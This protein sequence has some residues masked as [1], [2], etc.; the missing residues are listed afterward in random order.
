MRSALC[1]APV[2]AADV[3]NQVLALSEAG[4]L[5]SVVG[6]SSYHQDATFARV[7]RKIAPKLHAKTESRRWKLEVQPGDCRTV[8][9]PEFSYR[10][11]TALGFRQT[12]PLATDEWFA[13]IDRAASRFVQQGDQLVLAREDALMLGASALLCGGSVARA[14]SSSGCFLN[15]T[16]SVQTYLLFEAGLQFT[17]VPTDVN[18]QCG[19]AFNASTASKG[20]VLDNY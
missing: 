14:Q 13:G 5:R 15:V 9:W 3:R 8:N 6:G 7:L 1:V 17:T 12:G 16:I 2:L 11:S 10:L 20:A 19:I 4:I 18:V